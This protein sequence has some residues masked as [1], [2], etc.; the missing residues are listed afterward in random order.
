MAGLLLISRSNCSPA[1]P[2]PMIRT[3]STPAF[4]FRFKRFSTVSWEWP[5]RIISRKPPTVIRQRMKSRKKTAREN[6]SKR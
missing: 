4:F 3:R 6:L 2:A 5:T 1:L